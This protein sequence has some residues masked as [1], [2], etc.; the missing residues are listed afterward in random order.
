MFEACCS[1]PLQDYFDDFIGW[2]IIASNIVLQGRDLSPG[3][4][5]GCLFDFLFN[6]HGKQLRS[7]QDGQ[8]SP[9]HFPWAGF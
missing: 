6:V 8:L 9:L 1:L 5:T 3:F 7:C 4:S 2:G